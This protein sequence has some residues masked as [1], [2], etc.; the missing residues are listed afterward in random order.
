MDGLKKFI[1]EVASKSNRRVEFADSGSF[2]VKPFTHAQMEQCLNNG[3]VGE[4]VLDGLDKMIE[5]MPELGAEI[6]VNC[7]FIGE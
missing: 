1:G 2:F 7:R 5:F 4:N 6:Y 3:V